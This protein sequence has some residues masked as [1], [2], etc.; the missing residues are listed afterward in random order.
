MGGTGKAAEGADT[1]LVGYW[2]MSEGGGRLIKDFAG[3]N[4]GYLISDEKS[5]WVDKN[6]SGAALELSTNGGYVELP[7]SANN[8]SFTDAFS[9][10]VWVRPYAADAPIVGKFNTNVKGEYK[11]YLDSECRPCFYR[12]A[13]P[14]ELLR[15][16]QSVPLNEWCLSFFP[17]GESF[18]S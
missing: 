8:L 18:C 4:S 12:E 10:E 6:H 13:A 3:E 7:G 14:Y 15:G 2:P 17:A 11:L 5:G 16:E 9:I 1:E